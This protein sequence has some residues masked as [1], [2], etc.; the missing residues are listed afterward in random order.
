MAKKKKTLTD[1]GPPALNDAYT[2]ML[3]ISLLALVVGC[4]LLAL[5]YLQY[6]SKPAP[7]PAKWTPAA[8]PGQQPPAEPPKQ[9]EPPKKDL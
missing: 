7:T 2:G 5:D 9:A 3:A 8:A 4:A 6:E 1:E